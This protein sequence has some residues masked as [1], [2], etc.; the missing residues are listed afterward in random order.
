MVE[1]YILSSNN[2]SIAKNLDL[3]NI[4]KIIAYKVPY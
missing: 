3:K 1:L 2:F 4:C